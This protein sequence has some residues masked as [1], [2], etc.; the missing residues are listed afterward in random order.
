MGLITRR[1]NLV[2]ENTFRLN[3]ARKEHQ[4][5][6]RDLLA[7]AIVH[8]T[9]DMERTR[10]V[11]IKRKLEEIAKIEL[12]RRVKADRGRKGDEELL[13]YLQPGPSGSKNKKR[14]SSVPSG[15]K[16]PPP[17]RP[18]SAPSRGKGDGMMT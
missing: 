9:L 5:H 8:K 18:I 13:P 3:M 4:A 1:G 16:K 11:E 6:V 7:Q 10:Q 12:V 17:L 14:P 15:K 2:S